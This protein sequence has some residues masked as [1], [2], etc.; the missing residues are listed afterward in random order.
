VPPDSEEVIYGATEE[1]NKSRVEESRVEESNVMHEPY[2]SESHP[3]CTVLDR[4]PA[5]T[6]QSDITVVE[7]FSSEKWL[8]AQPKVHTLNTKR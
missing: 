5:P 7:E 3:E 1:K 2:W 8:L 4:P 6:L